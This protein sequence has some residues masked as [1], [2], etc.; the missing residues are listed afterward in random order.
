MTMHK[1]RLTED[2]FRLIQSGQKRTELRVNDEKRRLIVVG[3]EIEFQNRANPTEL[4]TREV[5]R[6]DHYPDFRALYV[7]VRA[8]YPDYTEQTFV[9]RMR[10]YYPQE[11]EQKYGAVAIWLR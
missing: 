3:D 6:L 11:E 8:E 1:M 4:L 9:E 10:R 5:T 2:N 7:G